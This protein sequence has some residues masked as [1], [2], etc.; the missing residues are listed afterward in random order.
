MNFLRVSISNLVPKTTVKFTCIF[1]FKIKANSGF[2]FIAKKLGLN[3]VELQKFLGTLNPNNKKRWQKDSIYLLFLYLV[4]TLKMLRVFFS[5]ESFQVI[6]ADLTCL[7]ERI[8][9]WGILLF[10]SCLFRARLEIRSQ[11]MYYLFLGKQNFIV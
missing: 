10:H 4:T 1:F 11:S 7:R 2:S 6:Q 3:R 5:K 9:V 8:S